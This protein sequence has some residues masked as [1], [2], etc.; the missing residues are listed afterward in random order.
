MAAHRR[1]GPIPW[2]LSLEQFKE[3][4]Q[5][6]CHYCGLPPERATLVGKELRNGIDRVD[7]NL[8]YVRTNCVSCCATCN[9]MKMDMT[10]EA[11]MT[12]IAKIL[13]HGTRT[14]S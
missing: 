2:E 1:R 6:S 9:S 3:L 11:F 5:G 4:S 13:A 14:R 10:V 12:H 8:G 7:N